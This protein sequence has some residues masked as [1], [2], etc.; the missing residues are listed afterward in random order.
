MTIEPVN[1]HFDTDQNV[2]IAA[3]GARL[4]LTVWPA[5]GVDAPDHVVVGVHG[6]NDYANAFHMAAPY[7]AAHGVTTYAYDQRGFGR[8]PGRGIWPDEELMREDL[9]TAVSV[10]R[11]RHPDAVI[12]VVGISM[13]GAVAIS[14]F[15]SDEPPAADR[16]IASGPGLRGWGAMNPVY[17]ASLWASTH[18]RPGWVVRPPRK[19]VRIEPS[20]NDEMLRRTWSDPLM[21]PH[22]RIDQVY[23][24]VS[25][26]ETAHASAARL[27]ASVPTLLSYGANDYVIPPAGVK[28]TARVLPPSVR[29]VYYANG[30][31]MLL[32]DLQA[33]TVQADYLAFMRD[34]SQPPPSGAPKWPWR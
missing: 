25:L 22:N 29:T 15:G 18:T 32:R 2:F 23:G 10:A 11:A 5:E 28:R 4:G 14:A 24:V 19:L 17:R 31:H 34:P 9:R 13:G 6:M 1:P 7:W 27:P 3:D 16:L 12:T 33:E 20:D 8:S 30:Y 21:M 26:M